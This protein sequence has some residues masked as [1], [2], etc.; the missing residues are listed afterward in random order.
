MSEDR[1]TRLDAVCWSLVAASAILLFL[2]IY[3]KL[4]SRRG[5]WWDDH[6]L[7]ISWVC[8]KPTATIHALIANMLRAV[9]VCIGDRCQHQLIYCIAWLRSTHGD[10]Q[11]TKP[12]E[13]QIEHHH[14]G[15]LRNHRDDDRQDVIRDHFVPN[16]N[17]TMDEVLPYL[18]HHHGKTPHELSQSL[19]ILFLSRRGD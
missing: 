9:V 2:R 3:S 8:R 17:R 11:R 5:L 16:H 6:F 15:G 10:H 4:W 19:L 12:G 18:C 1:G 14:C 7:L 13:D